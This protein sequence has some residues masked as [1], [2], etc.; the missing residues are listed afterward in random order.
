M[1]IEINTRLD[2]IGKHLSDKAFQQREK[3]PSPS[4]GNTARLNTACKPCGKVR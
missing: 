4:C 3:E 2:V 1:S